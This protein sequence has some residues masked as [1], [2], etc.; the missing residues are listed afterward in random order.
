MTVFKKMHEKH[1]F[2]SYREFDE[3]TRMLSEA[4]SRGYVEQVPVM[5]PSRFSP[6]E[7]WYRDK[8]TGD[9]YSL[10]PPE[11]PARGSWRLI[12]PEDLKEPGQLIQ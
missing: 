1:G 4:I 10:D 9:I 6:T 3:L 8:E 11:F 5:K 7:A 12:D 2:D